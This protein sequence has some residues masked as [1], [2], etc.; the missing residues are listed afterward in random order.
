MQKSHFIAN[1][2]VAPAE[3]EFIPVIDPSDGSSLGEIARGTAHDV[4]AAVAAARSAIG[5]T[6]DGPWGALAAAQRGRLLYRFSAAVSEHAEE[7]AALEASDTGKSMKTARADVVALARYLEYYAGACDKLHGETL[8]YEAG[9][10]VM[11]VR[12]PHGVTAHIIPWNYPI[13]IFGRTVGA[14]LA[15]GNACVVKPAEDASLSV[16]RLAEIAAAIGFPS[17]AINVVTGYGHE[18]GA[19]LTEHRGIDHISFT[20]STVTGRRVGEAAARR[21]CPVTLELGGK[22]PQIVFEDADLDAALPVIV[23][24][25]VQNAGQTCSAGSRLLV[26]SSVYEQVLERLARSFRALRSGPP[27][28]ELDMG[29]LVNRKQYELVKSI[30]AKAEADG[31]Q[32]A[33]CGELHPDAAAAGFYQEAVLLRD[34]P[35]GHSLAQEEIFGP[36]LAAMPF[37]DEAEAIRL[38]N[39]TDFGLVAGVWTRD[40]ARQL[41]LARK[42]RCGQVF[43]NNYGAAGGVE[44]P[45]GGVKSSGYGREK[46]FEALLGFTVLKTI[47]VRHG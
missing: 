35:H 39:G 16:L 27:A 5:E 28:L 3:G 40:G 38:A 14:S 6:F 15:A 2:W 37:E 12:E 24:A 22:S 18:A 31:I 23:N 45:F 17:G 41:R 43:V 44:L 4:D 21:H 42:L 46:G 13:Q 7:L 34:V 20:G 33:A 30:L 36:V 25:I 47:A 10:M 9:Y 11:T 19:A 1:D 8:P 29:P 32:V 26:H